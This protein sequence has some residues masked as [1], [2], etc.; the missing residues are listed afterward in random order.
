MPFLLV[1]IQ[2]HSCKF[3]FFPLLMLCYICCFSTTCLNIP[4]SLSI[5]E[6]HFTVFSQESLL[7]SFQQTKL[8][9]YLTH[10]LPI[11]AGWFKHFWMIF[12]IRMR[13]FLISTDMCGVFL[14]FGLCFCNKWW[15]FVD[16]TKCVLMDFCPNIFKVTVLWNFAT[17]WKMLPCGS[18]HSKYLNSRKLH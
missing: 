1:N 2:L 15:Q 3:P 11:S 12:A 14:S 8:S 4:H 16:V 5:Q 7:E 9:T 10:G 13:R 6:I 18:R 17:H